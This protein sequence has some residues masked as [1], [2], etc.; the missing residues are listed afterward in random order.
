MDCKRFSARRGT[1]QE[2]RRL[3]PFL[4]LA[5]LAAPITSS[6]TGPPPSGPV[7]TGQVAHPALW[8]WFKATYG[9]T[10][11]QLHRGRRVGDD[12]GAQTLGPVM[13]CSAASVP[14]QDC[15]IT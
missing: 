2:K 7:S 3:N 4:K 10:C 13:L 12:Q 11:T 9:A 8:L 1:N 15:S 14:P 6:S 5:H